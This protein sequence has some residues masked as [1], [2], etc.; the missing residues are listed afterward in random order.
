VF[1]WYRPRSSHRNQL[2]HQAQTLVTSL[3]GP[4]LLPASPITR[5]KNPPNCH[6]LPVAPTVLQVE[7][8][9][10]QTTTATWPI[11][12]VGLTTLTLITVLYTAAETYLQ[13]Q[14]GHH[15]IARIRRITVHWSM[16]HTY[17]PMPARLPWIP[18]KSTNS[19]DP[20]PLKSINLPSTPHRSVGQFHTESMKP[21]NLRRCRPNFTRENRH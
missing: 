13:Q 7:T 4:L 8:A 12:V 10:A 3:T 15:S 9:M 19:H 11:L 20:R 16:L 18:I 17:N 14:G 21:H 1:F 6:A 5:A 2:I